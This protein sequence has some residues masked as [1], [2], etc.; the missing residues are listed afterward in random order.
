MGMNKMISTSAAAL[1]AALTVGVAGAANAELYGIDDPEDTYHGSDILSLSVRNGVDNVHIT[2]HHS[3]L[4]R[5]AASGDAEL[6][7]VDTDKSDKGPEYVLAAGLFEGTDYVLLE[8]EGF[9]HKQWGDPVENGDYILKVRY[10]A[11]RAHVILSD[12][13]LG[14][15]DQV[16]VAVRASGTRTDGTS[17]GLVDWVG[18]PVHFATPWLD[19]A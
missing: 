18:K 14:D 1:V 13:A 19:H 3:N 10:K 6:V 17:K 15:P 8:T 9:G 16:R 5:K 12:A 11:D 2:T 7:Y 4:V